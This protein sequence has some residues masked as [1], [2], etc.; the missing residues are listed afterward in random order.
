MTISSY[1]WNEHNIS[2][3]LLIQEIVYPIKDLRTLTEWNE[4]KKWIDYMHYWRSINLKHQ[5]NHNAYIGICGEL[6]AA[7]F[8]IKDLICF[9]KWMSTIAINGNG[10]NTNKDILKEWVNSKNDIEI[11]TVGSTNNKIVITNEKRKFV[12][13]DTLLVVKEYADHIFY[14]HSITHK[15]QLIKVCNRYVEGNNMSWVF[16][17]DNLD[18]V[19]FT[20]QNLCRF[21]G[22]KID[23]D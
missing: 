20:S 17:L 9:E 11:K 4:I 14:I 15:Q 21:L 23:L 10:D 12:Y 7:A 22:Y 1:S 3:K 13:P 18:K 5:Y 6:F 16:K 8:L 19:N 2:S